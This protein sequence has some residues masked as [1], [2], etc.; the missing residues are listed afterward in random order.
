M[1]AMI[2]IPENSKCCVNCE[3]FDGGG[4]RKVQGSRTRSG[5]ESPFMDIEASIEEAVQWIEGA[6][7]IAEDLS[8]VGVKEASEWA[9]K[10]RHLAGLMTVPGGVKVAAKAE[11]EYL[12][13]LADKADG[14][15]Y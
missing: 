5:E 1:D 13:D 6:A 15:S 8:K 2:K 11:Q 7:D 14:Q 9:T 12:D 4:M 10:W 3:H